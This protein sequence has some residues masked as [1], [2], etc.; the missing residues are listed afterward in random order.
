[1]DLVAWRACDAAGLALLDV[2]GDATGA[3]D[4]TLVDLYLHGDLEATRRALRLAG[5][6]D[7]SDHW[8][9]GGL[10]VVQTGDQLDRGGDEPEITALLSRLAVEAVEAGG[11]VHVLNGNHELIN[12][13]LDFR[14]VTAGR[15]FKC[16]RIQ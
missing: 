9:G 11:A 16:C 13:G 5:A 6:I 8:I 7:A 1:M 3:D 15:V 12:V 2:V 4:E 10:V 14:Y